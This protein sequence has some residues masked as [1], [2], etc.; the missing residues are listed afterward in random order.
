MRAFLA[1]P[2]GF[3][4]GLSL[5]ALG[6]G[7]SIL[8]VPALVYGA[9][10]DARAATGTSLLLVG[11]S[12]FV[13][14]QSHRRAGRVRTPVGII[15]GLVG[16]G[17]SAVGTAINRHLDPD[18]LLVGFALLVLV[19]AWRMLTSCPTCTKVG[20]ERELAET[21][22]EGD[23]L[24]G[25][26]APGGAG[27]TLV[28]TRTYVDARTVI[29]VALAGTAVGFLT[30]LFGVGGGF[31]IVPALALVLKLPMPEAIGTS[32]LVISINSA[33]AL[34]MRLATTSI[35]WGVTLPFVVTAIAGVITGG[36]LAGKLDP[37][38]SLRAFSALLVAVALYTGIQ[39]GSA[40]LS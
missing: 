1:S 18:L 29:A 36:R 8:A 31:V 39:A 30:G 25:P 35:E 3:L 34:S 14:L 13:G 32:L 10:Q 37:E 33:V 11:V 16:I 9:G 7:G 24:A 38:R 2:L 28:R 6:G 20:E 17:G 5:G 19:A 4:I 12:S 21:L 15:F 27:A 23:D 22:E 40:L 26:T